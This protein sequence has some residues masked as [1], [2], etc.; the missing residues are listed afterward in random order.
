[1]V[2]KA[3]SERMLVKTNHPISQARKRRQTQRWPAADPHAYP[4]TSMRLAFLEALRTWTLRKVNTGI[5][6]VIPTG[7][8]DANELRRVVHA[9]IQLQQFKQNDRAGGQVPARSKSF[10]NQIG[11]ISSE[12]TKQHE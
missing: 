10:V 7:A 8:A 2:R 5:P 11:A 12:K 4:L 1:V 3:V 9:I 6:I